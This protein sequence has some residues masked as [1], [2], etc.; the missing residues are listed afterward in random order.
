VIHPKTIQPLQSK[1]IPLYV[2]SFLNPDEPG[3]TVSNA[4]HT[5]IDCPVYILK[6]HQALVSVS[7][8]DFSFIVEENLSTIFELFAQSGIK[9]NLM[10]N[11]AISF[12]ACVNDDPE[13]LKELYEL[14]EPHFRIRFNHG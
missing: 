12:S 2:R 4:S 13:K 1:N 14:L 6:S 11:S 10:Q 3:T 5:L 9:T 7:T 8:K